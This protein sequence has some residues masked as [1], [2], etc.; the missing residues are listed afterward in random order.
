MVMSSIQKKNN[1]T[2]L[3]KKVQAC[4]K[5]KIMLSRSSINYAFLNLEKSRV[6]RES[7]QHYL[8]GFGLYHKKLQRNKCFFIILFSFF[9][10][11][12]VGHLLS[13]ALPWKSNQV[14]R[15]LKGNLLHTN[16]M[17]KLN[18]T[19][20]TNSLSW[21][22]SK[23]LRSVIMHATIPLLWTEMHIPPLYSFYNS[24]WS[25]RMQAS[26]NCRKMNPDSLFVCRASTDSKQRITN[27]TL[28]QLRRK[29][30]AQLQ[31]G[32]QQGSVAPLLS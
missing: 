1:P 11:D 30:L 6:Y 23:H 28:H 17:L 26:S 5:G 32:R 9:A 13:A 14:I 25:T 31:N 20:E 19:N 10:K 12:V 21:L 15:K 4:L 3:Y 16:V 8:L 2:T 22:Q 18:L 27:T 29:Y 24:L 7:G